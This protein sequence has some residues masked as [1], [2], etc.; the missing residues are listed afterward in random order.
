MTTKHQR[1]AFALF[2]GAS[3]ALLAGCGSGDGDTTSMVAAEPELETS[4]EAR[5]AALNCTEFQNP[6]KPPVLL[7]HGTT[8]NGTEQFTVFYTPQLVERGFDVCI[9]TYPDRGLGD[10]QIS[11]EYIVHALRTIYAETGRKVAM[12]GHSQ[13]AT[14]P[15][16]AL[17]HWA[18][19]REAVADFVLIAGPNHGTA[20][21]IPAT[22]GESLL[23][24]LGLSALPVGILP[25]A[26][27]QFAPASDFVAVLNADDETPGALEYT[28]LYTRFDELVRPVEPVPTAALDFGKDNP[29]VANILLQDICPGHLAEHLTIGTTDTLAFA[30]V[31][32]AISNPGPADPERAGGAAELCGL[33]PIDLQTLVMPQRARDLL[34]IVASTL[35]IGLPNPHL[36]ASEPP[37]KPYAEDDLPQDSEGE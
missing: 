20:I 8:T 2:L 34:T 12:I 10:Q 36:A 19:A 16:W 23:E 15:R 22:I 26:F 25:E 30:L 31:L 3:M 28:N 13:G 29:K 37:L 11:A 5:D 21:A 33:L 35:Q 18:S 4:V 17:K 14:M 7:V 27:Y 32:D 6:D 1:S 9:V 24:L